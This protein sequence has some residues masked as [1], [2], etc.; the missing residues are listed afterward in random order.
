MATI[1]EFPKATSATVREQK[2]SATEPH[3]VSGADIV[4]FPGIRYEYWEQAA[5]ATAERIQR[6]SFKAKP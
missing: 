2:H 3:P 6:Q 4:I 5:A 1:L